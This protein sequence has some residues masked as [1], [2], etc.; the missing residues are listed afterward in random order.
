[1]NQQHAEH[2]GG[3]DNPHEAIKIIEHYQLNFSLGNVIKYVLRAGLKT[4]ETRLNDLEKA[5]W[6]IERQIEIERRHEAKS[7]IKVVLGE[8]SVW[9]NEEQDARIVNARMRGES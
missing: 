4:S 6:Y 9:L 3:D 2:Y 7:G 8:K 1:M 5:K